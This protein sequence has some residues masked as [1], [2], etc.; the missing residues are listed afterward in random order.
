MA[1]G[2][3]SLPG[4]GGEILVDRV[5]NRIAPLKADSAAWMGVM[6]IA[7][8]LG[9]ATSITMMFGHVETVEDRIEH[10]EFVRRQQDVSL[11]RLAGQEAGGMAWP[12]SSAPIE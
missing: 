11:D 1:A 8:R 9:L 5:R 4:G 10:L 3:G 12:A 6:D 7:H 2:L